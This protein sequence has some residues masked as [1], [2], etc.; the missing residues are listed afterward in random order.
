MINLR[1]IPAAPHIPFIR[2]ARPLHLVKDALLRT[3][4]AIQV[5]IVEEGRDGAVGDVGR[6][7]L[8]GRVLR[9]A[10]GEAQVA[11]AGGEGVGVGFGV[12]L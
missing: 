8:L 3:A 1:C 6:G 11:V 10:V 4:V 2:H 9:A 7:E 5:Q 12:D